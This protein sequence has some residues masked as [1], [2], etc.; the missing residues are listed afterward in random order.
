MTLKERLKFAL[1]RYTTV[2]KGGPLKGSRWVAVSGGKFV[3]GSYEP[4]TTALF[5]E[6]VRK[7]D[8][9]FDIGAHVGYYAVLSAMLTGP[10][11]RVFAFEPRPFNLKCLNVHR[12]SNR[13][14]N[15]EIFN[16]CVGA[17][18][19]SARF[20]TSTGSGTGHLASGGDLDVTVVS[21]DT[22]IREGRLVAPAMMKIDVEGAECDVLEG[23]RGLIA[24]ARPKLLVSLHSV[25]LNRRVREFLSAANYEFR[26]FTGAENTKDAELFAWPA[27][28]SSSEGHA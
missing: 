27:D 18:C 12:D 11:G 4:A 1:V 22:W 25:Q 24:Q 20:E 13:L 19:S 5:Q 23:A 8:V 10:T 2:V 6:H 17:A 26:F 14:T 21:L 28:V 7:G 9:V 15:L 16:V 3:R